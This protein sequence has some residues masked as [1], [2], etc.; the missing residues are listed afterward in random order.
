MGI[1]CA[2]E[3]QMRQTQAE[4]LGDYLECGEHPMKFKN[5]TA[6]HSQGGYITQNVPYVQ[7]KDLATFVTHIMDDYRKCGRLTWHN[8]TIPFNEMWVKLGGDHGGGN[9]KMACQIVNIENVNSKDNTVV[10]QIFEAKDYHDNLKTALLPYKE[11]VNELS[12]ISWNNKSVRIFLFGDTDFL[13]KMLSL[14]GIHGVYL[15]PF[16]LIKK[17]DIQISRNVRGTSQPRTLAGCKS[18]AKDF[19]EKS[20]SK[21]AMASSHHNVL[22]DPI[23]D[24]EVEEICPPYLHIL[25]GIVK[26][27]HDLL[28]LQ[29]HELD[30]MLAEV[31]AQQEDTHFSKQVFEDYVA[32]QREVYRLT[33]QLKDIQEHLDTLEINENEPLIR[34][35]EERNRLKKK[36]AQAEQKM[37]TLREKSV[38][39]SVRSGPITANLEH[40]LQQNGIAIQAFHSRSFN[41][42]HSRF[43]VLKA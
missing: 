36:Y 16:C 3:R 27:H 4:V 42:N 9:F 26:R 35:R 5:D 23:W 15:C 19:R 39:L 21:R 37:A 38:S 32:Q 33:V 17:Q 13:C 30:I 24:I 7:V 41:G 10:F 11:Q 31:L 12:E 1:E 22:D 43:Q 18:D 25:L 6:P 14:S 20:G 40:I 28:E 8:G 34:I 2:S 29:C